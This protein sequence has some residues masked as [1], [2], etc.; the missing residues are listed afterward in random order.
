MLKYFLV[1]PPAYLFQ[2]LKISKQDLVIHFS[3][4]SRNDNSCK[5]FEDVGINNHQSVSKQNLFYDY[6]LAGNLSVFHF[7]NRIGYRQKLLK[8]N[9][10]TNQMVTAEHK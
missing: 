4:G 6:Y 5:V 1:Y 3:I 8:L 9:Q 2:P 7:C 10:I